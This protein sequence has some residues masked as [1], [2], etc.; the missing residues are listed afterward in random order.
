MIA[1][2]IFPTAFA[3]ILKN[4]FLEALF[5]VIAIIFIWAAFIRRPGEKRPHHGNRHH[6]RSSKR[7][8]KETGE[9]PDGGK[10]LFGSKRRHR[11]RRK[12]RP[13]NPTLAETGGL[14]PVRVINPESH[15]KD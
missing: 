9:A 12:D 15:S 3:L 14:P 5:L 7:E 13:A 2:T 10:G 8:K 1:A 11:K 4:Q 6:W